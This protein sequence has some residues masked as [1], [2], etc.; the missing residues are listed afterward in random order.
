MKIKYL[1]YALAIIS[2]NI[3]CQRIKT[4]KSNLK[5]ENFVIE[6]NGEKTGLYTI[7]NE[8]GME[9][10]LTN[11]GGRIVSIMVPDKNGEFRDVVLGF[12]N[13]K[14]YFEVPNNFGATI[15]RYGNRINQGKIM[16][17]DI[18]YQLP[19]NNFGHCLHGGPNGWDHKI[20][21]TKILSSNAI[22]FSL[23][24]NDG[25]AGFPGNVNASVTFSV[26]NDN[27]VTIKYSATTDK[28][29]IINMTNHSYFNLKGEPQTGV[30]DHTLFINSD[31]ITPIDSTFMTSGE[32]LN[33]TN[34]PFD[35]RLPKMIGRDIDK[36]NVQL[37]NGH[38]YDH[39][40]VLNSKGNLDEIAA[41]L[42]SKESGILL[43]VYT[44]E[45]GIQIYTGNF[46]DGSIYG[47]NGNQYIYRAS[48]C[49]ETQHYPDSPNKKN[50]P[51]V[52]VKPDEVYTST[53]IYK[54][55]VK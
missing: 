37:K 5:P 31:Y 16:I 45:P 43:E 12:D 46:L 8:N 52:V 34:T 22:K 42:Y 32:M 27:A 51:S 24:S 49:M 23:K 3:A 18:E 39:N 28:T 9:V 21:K 55:S 50:W 36:Q 26:S 15:G 48:I 53:C 33:V 10:C 44:D 38:G 41:R 25:E 7:S 29:T 20:M 1:I 19:Q 4:T 54:F 30:L 17:E 11:Y 6:K 40:W 13:I 14:E 35:F 2:M 47:K